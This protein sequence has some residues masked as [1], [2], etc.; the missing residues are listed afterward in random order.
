ML[1]ITLCGYNSFSV[2]LLSELFLK[3]EHGYHRGAVAKED[4]LTAWQDAAIE[5]L[6]A[7]SVVDVACSL[8]GSVS[9]VGCLCLRQVLEHLERPN[10]PV[11][12]KGCAA[13]SHKLPSLGVHHIGVTSPAINLHEVGRHYYSG[14]RVQCSEPFVYF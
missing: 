1:K 5:P 11:A 14:A 10:E 7:V 6:H 8:E 9:D 3:K 4:A 12:E 13:R 2:A